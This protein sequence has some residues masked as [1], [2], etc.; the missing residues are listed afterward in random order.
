MKIKLS[1][2]PVDVQTKVLEDMEMSNP[3][4]EK[5]QYFPED[6]SYALDIGKI[7]DMHVDIVNGIQVLRMTIVPK[8]KDEYK[9]VKPGATKGNPT[10]RKPAPK[11]QPRSSRSSNNED[12]GIGSK[13]LGGIKAWKAD[14]SPPPWM[15]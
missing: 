3:T 9:T 4:L 6:L 2:L 15:R 10:P 13:I 7:A 8:E 1:D 11:K 5:I 12:E 14:K